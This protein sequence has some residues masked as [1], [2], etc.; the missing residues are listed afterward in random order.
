[1]TSLVAA[2]SSLE[3]IAVLEPDDFAAA[4]ERQ[5]LQGFPQLGQG[6]ERFAAVGDGGVNDLVVHA[7]QFLGPLQVDLL[8]ALLD[9]EI[10]FA[11]DQHQGSGVLG[12][13]EEAFAYSAS[14]PFSLIR[15]STSVMSSTCSKR[16]LAT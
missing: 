2:R 5:G 14:V 15:S 11:A 1:M 12:D 9:G 6:L 7:A 8:G 10:I 4:E 3:E 16:E 13:S